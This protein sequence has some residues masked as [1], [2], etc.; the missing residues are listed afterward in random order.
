MG[1]EEKEWLN[2]SETEEV[3]WWEHP[4]VLMFIPRYIA[5]A[6]VAVLGIGL[7]MWNGWRDLVSGDLMYL[8]L[9]LTVL[10]VLYVVYSVAHRRSIYYVATDE[11]VVKKEGIIKRHTNPVYYSR[12]SNVKSEESIPERI[13]SFIVPGQEIGDIH[14]HTAD[15]ELGDVA[16]RDVSSIREGNRNIHEMMSDTQVRGSS[17]NDQR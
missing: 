13:I 14:I 12:I 6:L 5:G 4:T 16:F 15:D 17:N 10:G 11:K 8:P 2:L 7:Y 3:V 9:I 1:I